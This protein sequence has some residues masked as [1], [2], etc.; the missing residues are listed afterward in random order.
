MEYYSTIKRSTFEVVAVT[1]MN[2]EPLTQ[3]EVL[4]SQTKKSIY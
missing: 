1:W 2:L 4:I 3:S